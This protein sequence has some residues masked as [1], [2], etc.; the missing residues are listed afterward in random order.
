M[1]YC[2]EEYSQRRADETVR[3]EYKLNSVIGSKTQTEVTDYVGLNW[4]SQIRLDN[5]IFN[6]RSAPYEVEGVRMSNGRERTISKSFRETYSLELRRSQRE[7]FDLLM[8]TVLMADDL[9]V[10]DYNS[11]N[12]DDFVNTL[13]E[14]NGEFAPDNSNSR[15]YPSG[16]IEFIS[17]YSNNKKF[18]S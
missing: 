10:C 16:S 11:S 13:V 7:I 3:F 8:Y 12:N 14:V 15:P 6:N 5:A 18:Y 1:E 4:L 9:K 17:R 2:L